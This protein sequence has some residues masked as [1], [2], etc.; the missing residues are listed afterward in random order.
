MF[1]VTPKPSKIEM[2]C[3]VCGE[4]LETITDKAALETFRYG[5]GSKR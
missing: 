1:G 3:G 5:P 4:S 2:K